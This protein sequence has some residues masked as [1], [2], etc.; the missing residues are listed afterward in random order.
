MT[1]DN[2]GYIFS[3]FLITFL[4]HHIYFCH[5]SNTAVD[6]E[7]RA[8]Y[9]HICTSGLWTRSL[10]DVPG[11]SPSVCHSGRRLGASAAGAPVRAHVWERLT[12]VWKSSATPEN[13]VAAR[14]FLTGSIVVE[15]D[16]FSWG[17]ACPVLSSPPTPQMLHPPPQ[18]PICF[19]AHAHPNPWDTT[20][21]N[22]CN[23]CELEW[24]VLFQCSFGTRQNMCV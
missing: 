18:S 4:E 19:H 24:S 1:T 22:N 15:G 5:S 9:L 21:Y 20:N 13:N 8:I 23:N 3:E 6:P 14:C 12:S 17:K 2:T 11:F 10:P 16:M 7:N